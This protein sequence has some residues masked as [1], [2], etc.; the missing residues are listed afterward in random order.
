MMCG[1]DGRCWA[2]DAPR[3]LVVVL[4]FKS[5]HDELKRSSMNIG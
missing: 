3:T 5:V 4:V 2:V 1:R